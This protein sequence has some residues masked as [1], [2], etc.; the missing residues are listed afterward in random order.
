[1]TQAT[2]MRIQSVNT[3]QR[4][5]TVPG[6][7]HMLTKLV[8]IIFIMISILAAMLNFKDQMKTQEKNLDF[9][10]GGIDDICEEQNSAHQPQKLASQGALLREA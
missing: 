10:H 5:V 3:H 9:L 1:M 6:R 8:V 4:F 2:V 7:W